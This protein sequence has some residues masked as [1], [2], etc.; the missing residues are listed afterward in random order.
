MVGGQSHLNWFPAKKG[1]II[2]SATPKTPPG[3]VIQPFQTTGR[4]KTHVDVVAGCE[5]A[6]QASVQAQNWLRSLY[7]ACSEPREF[8]CDCPVQG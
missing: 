7:Q 6:Q 3:P 2:E 8:R 1:G 4:L 5:A